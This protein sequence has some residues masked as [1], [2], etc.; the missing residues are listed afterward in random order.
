MA[1]IIVAG[2][3]GQGVLLATD[4]I[5]TA[6]ILA[7]FDAKKSEVHGVAQRGGSVVS[8]VRYGRKIYSPLCLHGEVDLLIALEKLE[9]LRTAHFVKREGSIIVNNREIKPIQ[10]LDEPKPYPTGIEEFLEKKCFRV[11]RIDAS[12]LAKRIGNIRAANVV[13][14]GLASNILDLDERYWLEALSQILPAKILDLNKKAFAQGREAFPFKKIRAKAE[15]GKRKK[16]LSP[17]KRQA[18]TKKGNLSR[19]TKR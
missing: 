4:V 7:G 15:K 9:A 16:S 13:V 2:V 6:A 11:L 3:G 12:M 19:G 14:L 5:A 8:H 17:K 18:K 1:N 10:F